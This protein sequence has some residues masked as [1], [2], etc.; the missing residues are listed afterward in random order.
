MRRKVM[1]ACCKRRQ[2]AA[3]HFMRCP[4]IT[5]HRPSSDNEK[6]G[7]SAEISFRALGGPDI[8]K[9]LQKE[10]EFTQQF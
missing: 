10:S 5:R 1:L 2:H 4:D 8:S 7:V 9:A 3:E 6:A